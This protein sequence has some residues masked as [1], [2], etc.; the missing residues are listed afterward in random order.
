MRRQRFIERRVIALR[1]GTFLV[2]ANIGTENPWQRPGQRLQPGDEGIQPGIIETKAIY[3][4]VVFRK[5]EN[6]R[7]WIA[8]LRAWRDSAGFHEAKAEAQ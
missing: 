4:R 6:P 1:I 7:P 5:A 3:H 2:D 8:D